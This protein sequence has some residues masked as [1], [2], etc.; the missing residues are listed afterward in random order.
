M[1]ADGVLVGFGV[2]GITHMVPRGGKLSS[3]REAS[4]STP[5]ESGDDLGRSRYLRL[6]LSPMM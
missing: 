6:E 4:F 1:A 2:G 5:C 3:H